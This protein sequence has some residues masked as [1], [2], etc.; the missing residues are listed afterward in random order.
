MEE[1]I[2]LKKY[3]NRLLVDEAVKTLYETGKLKMCHP[4]KEVRANIDLAKEITEMMEFLYDEIPIL[5]QWGK[6]GI[7]LSFKKKVRYR[8]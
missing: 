1:I 5:E 8:R 4:S 7:K 2:P 3:D 6:N